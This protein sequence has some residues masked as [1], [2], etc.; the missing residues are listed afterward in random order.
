MVMIR[1]RRGG[2]VSRN[3]VN[4]AAAVAGAYLRKRKGNFKKTSVKRSRPAAKLCTTGRVATYGRY[5]LTK[6]R[7]S[8]KQNHSTENNVVSLQVRARKPSAY[9]LAMASMEP[10][11]YTVKGLS[12]YD[13]SVG[14]HAIANRKCSGDSNI[15]LPMHIWDL[16]AMNQQSTNPDVGYKAYYTNET[17]TAAAGVTSLWS[18]DATG[19]GLRT[20]TSLIPENV[21]GGYDQLPKRKMLHHW[22]HIKLNLYGCRKRATR[23]VVDLVMVKNENADFLRASSQNVEKQKLFDYLTRPF[24]FSNLNAGDPQSKNLIKIVKSYEVIIAPS[25]GDD[26]GGTAAAVPHMQTVN[27]FIKHERIRAYD[28]LRGQ[29]PGVTQ[30]P[31]TDVE[32]GSGIEPRTAPRARLYLMLRAMCP[33]RRIVATNI[34]TAVV[35]DPI[36]EPSYDIA[37]RHK[38][39]Q[40]T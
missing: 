28:W 25:S 9:K 7:R 5:T 1:N 20:F 33:E 4:A 6:R 34:G 8:L 12:Q 39:S 26:Y 35:A 23:F 40:P 16:T 29:P 36:S 31:G 17:A 14:F 11:W 30:D 15:E 18:N 22:S 2:G 38:F 3:L 32:D 21:S 37:L 24:M 19:S 10:Q 27:W 13:T